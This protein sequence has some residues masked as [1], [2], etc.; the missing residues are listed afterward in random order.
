MVERRGGQVERVVAGVCVVLADMA[1]GDE[2]DELGV[3]LVV[4]LFVVVSERTAAGRGE[5]LRLAARRAEQSV[6]ELCHTCRV[7]QALDEQACVAILILVL[8]SLIVWLIVVVVVVV[9]ER[10][11]DAR[12]RV[13]VA[14]VH[15]RR[16]MHA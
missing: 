6:H 12:D 1:V 4:V 7:V 5:R 15:A 3:V 14:A 9:V 8:L 11:D 2:R 16:R 10:G 13:V